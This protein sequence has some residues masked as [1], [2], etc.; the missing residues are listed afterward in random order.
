VSAGRE[1]RVLILGAGMVSRPAVRHFLDDASCRVTVA[2]LVP[3]EAEALVGGH[4]R[5]RPLTLDVS[6][7]ERCDAAVRD[8][9]LV[10]SL[11][12]HAFHPAVARAA[13]RHRA[14]MITASYVSPPMRAL[15]SEAREAGVTI[16]NEIG[17]DPG[18][19][20]MSAMSMIDAARE[21]GERI[22]GFT[23]CCGSLPAPEAA[24]EP[25]RYKFSWSPR[26]V[27]LA[28]KQ[29]ARY[30]EHGRVIE[31]PAVDLA[32]HV[33]PYDVEGV[34]RFEIYPNRDSLQYVEP[35]GLRGVETMLR[36]T[37]RYPGWAATMQALTRLG[38]LDDEPR[39]W[40]VGMTYAGF[41]EAFGIG[42]AG[43]PAERLARRLGPAHDPAVVARLLRA[44]LCAD[45]PLPRPSASPLT[46]LAERLAERLAFAPGER[47]LVILRHELEVRRQD[48]TRERRFSLLVAWGEE[49][50]DTATARTVALPCAVAGSLLLEGQLRAPG[51]QI[52]T[53]REI[54]RP[55]LAR[56]EPLGI[57]F[58][59]WS[60]PVPAGGRTASTP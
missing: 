13:I 59:E 49:N 3:A 24:E 18:I 55:I 6:D 46:I 47:D 39:D 36:A 28:A 38:L 35:Y 26:G 32:D 42:T 20:H 40:P 58:R 33:R 15:D 29:P 45:E 1:R 57:A 11:V 22:A 41:I 10:V 5:G 8:A 50:G 12:P 14:D 60:R 9:D 43:T 48:R 30:L 44:G 34:G 16:L 21:A 19:D 31:V 7:A 17:L 2:S 56:L 51:V 25:W 37:I 54:Y 52:P 23:S 27:L 4:P 53:R